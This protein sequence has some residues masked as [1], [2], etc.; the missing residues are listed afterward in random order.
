[1]EAHYD[2][3]I[4]YSGKEPCELWLALVVSSKSG[5][6]ETTYAKYRRKEVAHE[7]RESAIWCSVRFLE[8]VR[9]AWLVVERA[10]VQNDRGNGDGRVHL[11][12][13]SS[14]GQDCVSS[15]CVKLE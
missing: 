6:L 11:V 4:T 1:M 8:G 5:E 12:E 3:C 9:V 15:R 14:G 10:S 2:V 7:C 13:F